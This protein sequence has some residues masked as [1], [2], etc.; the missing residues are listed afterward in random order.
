V[1]GV[2]GEGSERSLGPV[3][4]KLTDLLGG[5]SRV[6]YVAEMDGVVG[7]ESGTNLEIL[8]LAESPEP[9]FPVP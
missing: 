7:I 9:K 4:Q 1:I 2:E 8:V 3:G 5:R 6:V